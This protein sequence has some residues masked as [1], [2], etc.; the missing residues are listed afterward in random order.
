MR[1]EAAQDREEGD[2]AQERQEVRKASRT[3]S[4]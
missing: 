2:E 3:E 4:L 1:E